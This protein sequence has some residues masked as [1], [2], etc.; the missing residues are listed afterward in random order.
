MAVKIA[1]NIAF[2]LSRSLNFAIAINLRSFHQLAIANRDLDSEKKIAIDDQKIADDSCL[3][4][5]IYTL[6]FWKYCL[7]FP[8]TT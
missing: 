4:L 6:S 3:A 5:L 2:L 8:K 7:M 1:K